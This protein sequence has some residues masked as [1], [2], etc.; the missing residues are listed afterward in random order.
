MDNYAY[1]ML[2][3][4]LFFLAASPLSGMLS[5]D[6]GTVVTRVISILADAK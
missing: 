6:V 4:V 1:F 3:F 5:E 2:C